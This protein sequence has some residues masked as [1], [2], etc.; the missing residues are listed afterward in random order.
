[1]IIERRLK[2]I[3]FIWDDK[4]KFLT[5]ITPE[6]E[7]KVGKTYLFSLIRFGLRVCQR[8][9]GRHKKPLDRKL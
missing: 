6:G 7:V 1:M 8:Q 3:K 9:W 5:I 2:S 4:L